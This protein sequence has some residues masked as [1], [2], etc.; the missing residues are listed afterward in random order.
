MGLLDHPFDGGGASRA[1]FINDLLVSI[2]GTTIALSLSFRRTLLMMF[3]RSESIETG[4]F[5]GV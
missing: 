5:K 3:S 1:V 2:E 4:L